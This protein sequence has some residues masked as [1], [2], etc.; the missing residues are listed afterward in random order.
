MSTPE[1]P[2]STTPPSATAPAAT[3]ASGEGSGAVSTR[4]WLVANR[5][6]GAVAFLVALLAVGAFATGRQSRPAT[7]AAPPV[8]V[9]VKKAIDDAV[10]KSAN[11]PAISAQVYR[12]IVPSL[13]FVST[14]QNPADPTDPNDGSAESPTTD[15]T[16]PPVSDATEA[17]EPRG[18]RTPGG[19][20]SLS[21]LG[22]GVVI[23]KDGL[24]L[25]AHHVIA[26][27]D[28]I[29][30]TFSDGTTAKA[31]VASEDPDN[32]T[33]V[34]EPESLPEVL[35]P[36]V[37][38]GGGRVGDE[39]YAVGHPLGLIGSMSAGVIS[40]LGRSIPLGRGDDE[41]T[42]D[43]LIQFDAAVNPGNSG[44]PLLNRSGQV[45]G[46]VTALANPTDQNFF[47]GIGFAVPIETAGAGANGPGT[48]LAR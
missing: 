6:R 26:G 22:T 40:G 25:T 5:K 24:I 9:E 39:V 11:A 48:G 13:V 43:G 4:R 7:R 19:N 21:G 37:L 17:G 42:L 18:R 46:I 41:Q 35:V 44:G 20:E 36:A 28:L 16:E 45:I 12:A 23:N 10:K 38:A 33:A 3:P 1:A 2:P 27:A 32:D 15:P 47:V 30:V 14:N 34:L 29:E 8:G 31:T